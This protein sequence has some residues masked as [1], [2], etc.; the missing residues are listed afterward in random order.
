MHFPVQNRKLGFCFLSMVSSLLS[1]VLLAWFLAHAPQCL[2]S[3]DG[4]SA[5]T[6]SE[7][8]YSPVLE[9]IN[10]P[11]N[12]NAGEH[13]ADTLVMLQESS[14]VP[15]GWPGARTERASTC[16]FLHFTVRCSPF[17]EGEAE[18]SRWRWTSQLESCGL[19]SRVLRSTETAK[20]LLGL[21]NSLV[22]FCDT[23][24]HCKTSLNL[25]W[26]CKV[27]VLSLPLE[28]ELCV[29]S[30]TLTLTL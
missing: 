4:W 10:L 8:S 24:F 27:E 15:Q 22:V 2:R 30:A 28:S 16:Q 12:W 25:S 9:L 19:I 23:A 3:W 1:L 5:Q 26:F 13:K 6:G 7:R 17:Q 18:V 20:C 29:G 11:G 21:A 14:C